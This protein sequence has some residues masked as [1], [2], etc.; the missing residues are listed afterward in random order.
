MLKLIPNIKPEVLEELLGLCEKASQI[1]L[2]RNKAYLQKYKSRVDS[3]GPQWVECREQAFS[4]RANNIRKQNLQNP[5]FRDKKKCVFIK[6]RG[7]RQQ[8]NQALRT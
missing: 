5:K 1:N 6:K 4:L 3:T 2:A 8:P 7:T